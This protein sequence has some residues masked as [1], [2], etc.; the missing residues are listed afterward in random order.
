MA[1]FWADADL[2]EAAR[3]VVEK[4]CQSVALQ[5]PESVLHAAHDVVQE[6]KKKLRSMGSAAK[7][8]SLPLSPCIP[9]EADSNFPSAWSQLNVDISQVY[10]L[11]STGHKGCAVDVVGA[12]RAHAEAIIQFGDASLVQV[13]GVQVHHVLPKREVK[14]E[15]LIFQMKQLVAGM[16]KDVLVVLLDAPY[17]HVRDQLV[18]ALEVLHSGI[19]NRQKMTIMPVYN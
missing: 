18:E 5:F 3:F 10:L 7:V 14:V 19:S 12:G 16:T 15:S 4:R 2:V 8:L 13:S 17:M 11:A 9:A 1:A 6:L